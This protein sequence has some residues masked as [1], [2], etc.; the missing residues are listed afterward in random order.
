M[1]INSEQALE[2]IQ[3]YADFCNQFA[4]NFAEGSRIVKDKILTEKNL[5]QRVAIGNGWSEKVQMIFATSENNEAPADL[6]NEY[7]VNQMEY[8]ELLDHYH[9]FL[10]QSILAS[11]F[12][13]ESDIIAPTVESAGDFRY[14]VVGAKLR[15]LIFYLRQHEFIDSAEMDSYISD[16]FVGCGGHDHK[17]I[18][19]N[20]RSHRIK[21]HQQIKR[22]FSVAY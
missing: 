20:D 6:D 4:D 3:K 21:L 5:V 9:D 7:R 17:A 15:Y 2:E 11:S 10:K 8:Q 1:N 14:P 12:A 19:S 18:E 22:H 13:A 16:R